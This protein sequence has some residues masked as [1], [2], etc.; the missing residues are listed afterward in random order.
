MSEPV[1]I[2]TRYNG[3]FFRSKLEARWAVFFDALGIEWEYEPAHAEVESG[4]RRVAYCPDFYL[5][6]LGLWIEIKPKAP[7]GIEITKAAGWAHEEDIYVFFELA[8]PTSRSES[9]WWIHM[10]N[11]ARGFIDSRDLPVLT[12]GCRWTECRVCGKIAITSIGA[13][14]WGCVGRCYSRED[15]DNLWD[16]DAI[17]DPVAACNLLFSDHSPRLLD[18][19]AAANAAPLDNTPAE[20]A[21]AANHFS[22]KRGR[23]RFEAGLSTYASKKYG[24]DWRENEDEEAVREEFQ[25]WVSRRTA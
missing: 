22:E 13:A 9:A 6:K 8:A 17:D 20:R 3:H 15:L 4:L 1:A 14:P 10:E 7:E 19:Y 16:D 5:P 25:D 18:A 23:H 2:A 24:P 11:N 21:A 12:K